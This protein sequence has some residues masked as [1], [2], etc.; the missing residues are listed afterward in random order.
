[1]ADEI[2]VAWLTGKTLTANV[3]KPDGTVRE[4]GISLTENVTGTLYLGD[5]ATIEVGDI[6]VTYEAGVVLGA[7]EYEPVIIEAGITRD[8]VLRLILSVLTGLSTGGGTDT[9]TFRNVGDT[10]DRLV[11]T[12]DRDGN[13]T[14]IVTRDGS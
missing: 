9:I 13:R 12:V 6:I 11:V 7:S 10:K 14:V 3:F 4:T 8:E 5:C 2:H 1:M